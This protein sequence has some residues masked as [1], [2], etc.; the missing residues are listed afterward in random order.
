MTSPGGWWGNPWGCESPLR[1]HPSLLIATIKTETSQLRRASHPR[2]MPS[3]ALA[4][5]GLPAKKGISAFRS[6][7]PSLR[8]YVNLYGEH[9]EGNIGW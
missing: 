3:E 4:K 7:L 1:H 2:R 9:T 5:E 6:D 8:D